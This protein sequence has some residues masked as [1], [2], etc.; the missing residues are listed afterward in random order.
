MVFASVYEYSSKDAVWTWM[1]DNIVFDKINTSKHD[2]RK[3]I[4]DLWR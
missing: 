1:K 3:L 2:I 4:K